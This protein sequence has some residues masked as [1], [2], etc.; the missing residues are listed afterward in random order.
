[1]PKT[2]GSLYFDGE[3]GSA[4]NIWIQKTSNSKLYFLADGRQ[5]LRIL[6]ENIINPTPK[7]TISFFARGINPLDI[8]PIV[9]LKLNNTSIHKFTI[10]N[11]TFKVFNYELD[12]T[13][14]PTDKIEFVFNNWTSSKQI[15]MPYI[16][17][18]GLYCYVTTSATK[19]FGLLTQYQ[20]IGFVNN[21]CS[22]G[23]Q[24]YQCDPG[25][26]RSCNLNHLQG[27]SVCSDS[28]AW[29]SCNTTNQCENGYFLSSNGDCMSQLCSPNST[30]EC[31]ETN[32]SGLKTCS[33]TGS[34][35]GTCIISRCNAGFTFQNNTCVP[36]ICDPNSN[37]SCIINHKNGLKTCSANGLSESSC[38]ANSPI[39]CESSF[40]LSNGEC[41]PTICS[42]NSTTSCLITNGSG[43]K[44]C[45]SI[46]SA[47]GSCGANSCNP[48]YFLEN[49]LCASQV[50]SP[51]TTTQCVINHI[52]GVKTCNTQGSNYSACITGSTCES[53]YFYSNGSCLAQ[54]CTPGINTACV[55]NHILGSKTCNSQG[56]DFGYCQLTPHCESGY[57]YVNNSCQIITD[58]NQEL[59]VLAGSSINLSVEFSPN[60]LIIK[61]SMSESSLNVS[62]SQTN[63]KLQIS[64]DLKKLIYSP[65]TTDHGKQ[66]ITLK[67]MFDGALI[68]IP[69]TINV[70][71]PFTWTGANS[72]ILDQNAK[73]NFCGSVNATNTSCTGLSSL[74]YDS[75]QNLLY[76][77]KPGNN[78]YGNVLNDNV[79]YQFILDDTCTTNCNVQL[80]TNLY[81]RGLWLR[82][83]SFTQNQ[84]NITYS[85]SGVVL[86]NQ[87]TFNGGSGSLSVPLSCGTEALGT[88]TPYYD[89]SCSNSTFNS[90]KM[91]RVGGNF[92][93]SSSCTFNHTYS[94]DTLRFV[95]NTDTGSSCSNWLKKSTIIVPNNF[96]VNNL[97][98]TGDNPTYD[99]S[100]ST[101]TVAGNLLFEDKNWNQWNRGTLINGTIDVKGNLQLMDV[102]SVG[103]LLVKMT[104]SNN[105]T[106]SCPIVN[107]THGSDY[108]GKAINDYYCMIPQ[109]EINK[110]G[111]LL[112]GTDSLRLHNKFNYVAGS[113]DFSQMIGMFGDLITGYGNYSIT[114]SWTLPSNSTT[115]P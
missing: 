60:G 112:T 87:A 105:Q 92:T 106:I 103:N 111:G 91:V 77:L 69:V 95:S 65:V 39:S 30:T 55:S 107:F 62:A 37:T 72:N 80:K 27:T 38:I 59:Y 57:S 42:P 24:S 100:N 22:N 89:F 7:T 85:G 14:S 21:N 43:I 10:D 40:Y 6:K 52:N 73:N 53:G 84:Y 109:L 50:C 28:G 2:I 82:S 76:T 113:I 68:S 58:T 51:N 5:G 88:S 71:T 35:Y 1:M 102:R 33:S 46:G 13:I 23:V 18:N 56:S 44:T 3:N 98:F 61:N 11:S 20:S 19:D 26:T 110:S 79:Y 8:F 4:N 86:E 108:T 49:G 70:M 41:L 17:V 16:Q 31:I 36:Q 34:N 47:F 67:A 75:N 104:G 115:I 32:G 48:G 90:S 99:L 66:I 93:V 29:S 64:S 101:I 83:N 9:D 96:S 45:N 114:P 15:I 63:S 12:Q 74:N 25:A 97:E 81:T 78:L 54:T 94:D